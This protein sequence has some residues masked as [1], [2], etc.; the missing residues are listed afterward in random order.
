MEIN[1]FE[2]KP[3]NFKYE[4]PL[5]RFC[6]W[7]LIA[8]IIAIV[9]LAIIL[10]LEGIESFL[11]KIIIV[12]G[13]FSGSAQLFFLN[14]IP[15]EIILKKDGIVV[16]RGI[17]TKFIISYEK[18]KKVLLIENSK[19]TI[20]FDSNDVIYYGMGS[21]LKNKDISK[22]DKIKKAVL[23]KADKNYLLG[24]KNPQE[25]ITD[26]ENMIRQQK[27]LKNLL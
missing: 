6:R 3:L 10:K 14:F 27:K 5:Y 20:H 18:I 9:V 8:S 1:K 16:K 26:L 25:F 2:N 22:M 17:K 7:A 24:I 12:L 11:L 15:K 19:E 23:I 13:I 4:I 21:L